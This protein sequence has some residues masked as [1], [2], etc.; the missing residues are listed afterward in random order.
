MKIMH[1]LQSPFFS[2]AE[3]VVCQIIKMLETEKDLDFVYCSP[4]GQIRSALEERGIKFH[5]IEQFSISGLKSVLREEKPDIVHAH[6]MRASF[7][8][9]MSCSSERLISHLH[10]N[11]FTNRNLNIKSIAY[12]IPAFRSSHIFY[13]SQSA[14]KGYYFHNW[15][16]RKSSVLYN[17]IKVSDLYNK[18][19]FDLQDYNYDVVFLGRLTAP[20]DPLRL[21]DVIKCAVDQKPDLKVAIIGTG[22][23]QKETQEK[24]T[25]LG[26]QTNIEFLGYLSNPSKILH[27]AKLMLM[28]SLWEGT[29][30]CALEAMALGVPIVTTPTDG[31]KELV[32]HGVTGYLSDSNEELANYIIQIT[33]DN[34]VYQLMHRASKERSDILNDISKY[35]EEILKIY[36]AV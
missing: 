6:D 16:K 35:K 12:T 28:T 27:D 25:M 31:L 8:A 21:V 18:M 9:A 29:P 2:G 33:S 13:V 15:F 24:S 26:L 17:V 10:N 7:I 22:D 3:N 32:V 14:Y 36:G 34:E 23:L 1:F 30:M 20:K 4:D 5:P 11:N 19:T